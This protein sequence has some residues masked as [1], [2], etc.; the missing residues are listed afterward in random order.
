VIRAIDGPIL[1]TS[2]FNDDGRECDQSDRCIVRD[3]L[4][5]VH[6][7]ILRLLGGISIFDMSQDDKPS[8]SRSV[9]PVLDSAAGLPVFRNV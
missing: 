1:L 4:R 6:E 9:P 8:E 5:K 2:C 3:P 7:G